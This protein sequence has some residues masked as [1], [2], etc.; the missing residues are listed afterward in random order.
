M[1]YFLYLT[2]L[3][4]LQKINDEFKNIDIRKIFLLLMALITLCSVQAQD[5]KQLKKI[6]K[7]FNTHEQGSV[8]AK[9]DR[10]AILGNNLRFKLAARQ[11]EE[12]S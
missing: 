2:K 3:R 1:P 10:V 5:K 8:F 6:K 9:A 7:K 12:A 11:S 4:C